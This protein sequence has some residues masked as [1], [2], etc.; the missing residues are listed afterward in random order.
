MEKIIKSK[1]LP[2]SL[3]PEER[4]II[5]QASKYLGVSMASFIRLCTVKEAK[6]INSEVIA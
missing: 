6:K 3:T 5:R 1:Q 2:I 4:E